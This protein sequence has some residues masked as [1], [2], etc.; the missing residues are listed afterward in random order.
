MKVFN[1]SGVKFFVHDTKLQLPDL[2]RTKF[3]INMKPGIDK[4]VK[5]SKT[6]ISAISRPPEKLCSVDTIEPETCIT[7]YVSSLHLCIS[8]SLITYSSHVFTNPES[9]NS[10]LF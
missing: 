4:E 10:E 2:V 3:V 6:V 5:F 9:T 1:Q 7:N 8:D